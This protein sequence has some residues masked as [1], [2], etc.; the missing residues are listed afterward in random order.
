MQFSFN[1]H[2]GVAPSMVLES[3]SKYIRALPDGEMVDSAHLTERF[4][5]SSGY[6][7]NGSDC[8]ARLM[9]DIRIRLGPKVWYGKQYIRNI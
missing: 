2:P 6:F 1:G 3:I 9:Q 7:R 4:G 5:L 8:V